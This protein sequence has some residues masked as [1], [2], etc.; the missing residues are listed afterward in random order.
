M[1]ATTG[2][3]E[4]RKGAGGN[5]GAG[6]QHPGPAVGGVPRPRPA[7][8]HVVVVE[9]DDVAEVEAV[10]EGGLLDVDEE[11]PLDLSTSPVADPP[12]HRRPDEVAGFVP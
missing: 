3:G 4:E 6:V 1:R 12:H 5:T 9:D 10:L 11:V 8:H 2:P 7:H